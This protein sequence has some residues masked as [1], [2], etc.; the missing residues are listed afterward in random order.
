MVYQLSYRDWDHRRRRI[1]VF[2]LITVGL[3]IVLYTG[4]ITMPSSSVYSGSSRCW[5]YCWLVVRS[6]RCRCNDLVS[7]VPMHL[8]ATHRKSGNL[9]ALG[10]ASSNLWIGMHAITGGFEIGE[11]KVL[12]LI[13]SCFYL[14]L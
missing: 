9:A 8:L 11:L 6:G 5:V 3:N 7:N 12:A 13:G 4:T 14:S 10:N 2:L 1:G